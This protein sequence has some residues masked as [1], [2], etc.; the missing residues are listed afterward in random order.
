MSYDFFIDLE[1]VPHDFTISQLEDRD[2]TVQ[3]LHRDLC[4]ETKRLCKSFESSH[5]DSDLVF[6]ITDDPTQPIR[7]M[8]R[9]S[10]LTEL[11]FY[12]LDVTDEA[13]S[14]YIEP[15]RTRTTLNYMLSAVAAEQRRL[16][17]Y[18]CSARAI[19]V[20]LSPYHSE[21]ES[22]LRLVPPPHS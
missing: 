21:M 13:G 12:L 4:K 5:P 10:R 18:L 17:K 1:F 6:T 9:N 16:Q 8:W 14:I 7:W 19:D 22:P 11:P 15:E 2:R 20:A 3:I